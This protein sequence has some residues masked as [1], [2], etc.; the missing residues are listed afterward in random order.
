MSRKMMFALVVLTVMVTASAQAEG[1]ATPPAVTKLLWL[2]GSWHGTAQMT[3]TGKS[4][5]KVDVDIQCRQVSGG[6][7]VACD[8]HMAWPGTDY[9]ETDLFGWN[10][11]AGQVHWYTVTNGGEVHD[12]VGTFEGNKLVVRYTGSSSGRLLTEDVALDSS[13]N[14]MSFDVLAKVGGNVASTMTGKVTRR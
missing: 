14:A 11:E 6:A 9:L 13:S 3:D 8:T 12:H 1:P 7:G 5:V 2:V 10:A 4:P